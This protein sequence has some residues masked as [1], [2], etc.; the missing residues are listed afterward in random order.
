MTL[1]F[2][3]AQA[4]IAVQIN[5]KSS[6]KQETVKKPKIIVRLTIPASK[7]KTKVHKAS[8]LQTAFSAPKQKHV[9]P[10]ARVAEASGC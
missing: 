6:A 5:S 3:L 2:L 1:I 4:F 8:N 10:A 7:K 9:P